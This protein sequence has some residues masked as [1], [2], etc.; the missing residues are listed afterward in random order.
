MVIMGYNCRFW[1]FNGNYRFSI[2][3]FLQLW[4]FIGVFFSVFFIDLNSVKVT[5]IEF[6][7]IEIHKQF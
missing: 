4:V 7:Y 2:V 6:D 1:V 3:V 5:S